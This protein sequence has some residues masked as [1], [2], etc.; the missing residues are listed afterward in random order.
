MPF[1][2]PLTIRRLN[3]LRNHILETLSND[4]DTNLTHKIEKF[5]YGAKVQAIQ[6]IQIK[7]DLSRTKLAESARQMARAEKNRQLQH[8]EIM[9][10]YDACKKIQK[11]KGR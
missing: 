3:R 10:V 4:L 11:K 2:T 5:I 8:G 1:S 7:K 6:L 9:S